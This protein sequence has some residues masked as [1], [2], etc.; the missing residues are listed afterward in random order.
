MDETV[1]PS[2]TL[3]ASPI[4]DAEVKQTDFDQLL[5]RLLGLDDQDA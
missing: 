5:Y 1:R 4:S 2:S 3:S